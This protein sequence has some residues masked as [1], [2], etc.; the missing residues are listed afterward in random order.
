MSA[1]QKLQD[2]EDY[3][4]MNDVELVLRF[5]AYR[6][7]LNQQKSGN[8]S[9]Y[10]DNFLK[11]GN[12]WDKDVRDGL[13]DLFEKTIQLVY[14][15]FEEKAFW[16]MRPNKSKWSWYKRPTT[17]YD[18]LMFAFSQHIEKRKILF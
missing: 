2:N 5:F 6:Q 16:V 13:E 3:R 18:P 4:K 7:R 15:V 9:I 1:H 8:L 14:E 10:L 17:V 11:Y 12:K